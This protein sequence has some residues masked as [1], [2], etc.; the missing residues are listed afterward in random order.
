MAGEIYSHRSVR[1]FKKKD[2]G[3]SEAAEINTTFP[4]YNAGGALKAVPPQQAVQGSIL[5]SVWLS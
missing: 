3:P 2:E 4:S 1:A 5:A